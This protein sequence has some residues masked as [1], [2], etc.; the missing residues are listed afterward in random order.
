MC[1]NFDLLA[2]TVLLTVGGSRAYGVN[3]PDSDVDFRGVAIPPIRHYFGII[4]KF[5]QVDTIEGISQLRGLL[6]PEEEK[7]ASNTK[8]EGSVYEI[9]KFVR[10]AMQANPNILDLLF[11]DMSNIRRLT[12]AGQVLLENRQLFVTMAARGSYLGCINAQL[13]K[14]ERHRNW[15][16]D[17][18][19]GP[20]LNSTSQERSNWNDY[21]C[22][23]KNQGSARRASDA[24]YGYDTKAAGHLVRLTRMGKEILSSGR[25]NVWRGHIDAG[26]LLEIRQGHWTYDEVHRE[27]S[28]GINRINDIVAARTH[29]IPDAPDHVAINDICC[30]AIE[31]HFAST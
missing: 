11:G 18:P 21:L 6:T 3:M 15:M 29:V 16:L 20:I 7:A 10:M 25:V 14:M 17:P 26:E 2:G 23:V 12:A 1:L 24:K 22:W 4:D 28:D 27:V 31:T 9:R 13:T 5:E 8:L 19:T 30:Q